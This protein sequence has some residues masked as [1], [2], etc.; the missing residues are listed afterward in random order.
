[1]LVLVFSMHLMAVRTYK[2]DQIVPLTNVSH[3]F[4]TG[5]IKVQ[6]E[7]LKATSFFL[8]L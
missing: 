4:P 3:E 5:Q 2:I 1:M 8:S 6:K 7:K